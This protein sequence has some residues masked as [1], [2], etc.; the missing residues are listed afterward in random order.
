MQWNLDRFIGTK[1]FGEPWPFQYLFP[2]ESLKDLGPEGGRILLFLALSSLPFVYFGVILTAKRL[3]AMGLSSQWLFLFFVPLV[4]F[5]FFLVLCVGRSKTEPVGVVEKARSHHA[6]VP[7]SA[8]EED[9]VKQVIANDRIKPH[10][11]WIPQSMWGQAAISVVFWTPAAIFAMF[12]LHGLGWGL[13]L[14]IPFG[15]GFVAAV[16]R[17]KAVDDSTSGALGVSICAVLE[18]LV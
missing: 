14:G 18:T 17:R 7:Q 11:P 12:F 15:L 6:W 3:R 8:L 4:N 16:L 13:F 5:L 1:Y 9:E 2:S 10:H